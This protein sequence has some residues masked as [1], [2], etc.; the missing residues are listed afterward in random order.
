[1]KRKEPRRVL[2]AEIAE[3]VRLGQYRAGQWLRQADLEERFKAGRFEVRSAL[4]ALVVEKRLEH[5][6]NRGYLVP[7]RDPDVLRNLID[8]QVILERAAAV[9]IVKN[10]TDDALARINAL[11]CKFAEA[12][13]TGTKIEQDCFDR[14]LHR[15]LYGLTENPVLVETIW[16]IRDRN[17]PS[18]ELR[19][20][21]SRSLR[22]A[23]QQHSRIASCLEGRDARALAEA[24][25]CHVRQSDW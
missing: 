21:S 2:S 3:A 11:A 17:R 25:E 1:M 19:S 15:M 8:V 18:V 6:R 23:V 12:T 14:D 16:T 20:A 7:A 13:H 9:P 24:F 10:V 5:R 22:D 4:N